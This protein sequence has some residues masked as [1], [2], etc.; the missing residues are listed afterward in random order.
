MKYLIIFL[1]LIIQSK[2]KV[3][4]IGD[5][6]TC[7]KYGWQDILSKNKNYQYTNLSQGG[8]RTDWMLKTLKENLEQGNRYDK[9]YIYGGINDCFSNVSVEKSISNIQEMVNLSTHYKSQPIIIIGYDPSMIHGRD[10]FYIN[11]YKEFQIQLKQIKG[12]SIIE[13]CKLDPT[14][15]DD[16]IHLNSGGIKKFYNWIYLHD[17]N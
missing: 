1:L 5:S 8:K 14:D 3:C 2:T 7:Y 15:S 17:K 4:F 11:K 9:I 12:A 13:K 10:S 6:L 16:G